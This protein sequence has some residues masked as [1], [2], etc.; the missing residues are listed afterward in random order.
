MDFTQ[1]LKAFLK[2]LPLNKMSGHQKFLAIAAVQCGGETKAEIGA[3]EVKNSW[4]KAVLAIKYNPAFY[5]RAQG[6]V[7][8]NPGRT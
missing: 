2:H 4:P 7:S 8:C 6:Q 5:D 1:N 3:G